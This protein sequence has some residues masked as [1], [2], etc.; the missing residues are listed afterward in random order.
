[1]EEDLKSTDWENFKMKFRLKVKNPT[2]YIAKSTR[3]EK[4]KE[5]QFE[6]CSTR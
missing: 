1:M 4:I 2:D 6:F 3:A 5:V